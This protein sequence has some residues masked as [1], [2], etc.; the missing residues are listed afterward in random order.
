MPS[1]PDR[2]KSFRYRRDR[3]IVAAAKIPE[4]RRLQLASH[5]KRTTKYN[6]DLTKTFHPFAGPRC[7]IAAALFQRPNGA[8]Y[9]GEPEAMRMS[10]HGRR[11]LLAAAAGVFS[12]ALFAAP[13]GAQTSTWQIDPAHANAQFSVRHLGISNVSGQF[14]KMSGTIQ[15]D[16]KDVTKSSVTATVDVDSVDTR[17]D[18]RDKDLKSDGFFDVAKYPTFTF[19]STKITSAGPGK[20]TMVGNL[21]MHGVTKEVSFDVDGPSDAITDPWKNQRRGASATTTIHRTDFGI[22]KYPAAMIG[23]DVKITLDIEFVKK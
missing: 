2:A 8:T 13:S 6:Q 7:R 11:A 10:A 9:R 4:S 21:T 19:T 5:P 22:S 17:N 16:D 15:L 18:G 14:N 1:G 12:F 23:D 20:L 3:K